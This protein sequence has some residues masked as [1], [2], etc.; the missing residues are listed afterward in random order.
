M[1][2]PVLTHESSIYQYTLLKKVR[3]TSIRQLTYAGL[4]AG[5]LSVCTFTLGLAH[6]FGILLL[7][8]I[9]ALLQSGLLLMLVY[10]RSKHWSRHWSCLAGFPFAGLNPMGY[11]SFTQYRSVHLHM[12]F[13][14]FMLIFAMFAWVTPSIW[15]HLIFLQLWLLLPR[16]M[17]I[18]LAP[19]VHAS[20]LLVR[21]QQREITY[22]QS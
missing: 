21:I 14:S 22:V 16:G 8:P 6:L 5:Y 12:S 10:L 4:V 2:S 3:M 18:L 20:T 7:L 11:V 19:S 15:M 1:S 17:V 9:L 13:A